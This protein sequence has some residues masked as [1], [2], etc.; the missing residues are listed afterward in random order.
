MKK[1]LI[2]KKQ[3]TGD[4]MQEFI[5]SYYVMEDNNEEVYG[6]SLEKSQEGTDYIEVEEVPKISY[7][8]QL[9]ENVAELLMKYQVTPISLAESVDTILIMEERYGETVL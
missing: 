2:G 5:V 7:S 4:R 6:I 8:L 9:V 1:K 3:I